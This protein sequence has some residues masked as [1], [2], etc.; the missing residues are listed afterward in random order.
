MVATL[1]LPKKML[2]TSKGSL[3]GGHIPAEQVLAIS[4]Q[5][6]QSLPLLFSEYKLGKGETS[7]RALQQ[8]NKQ[9]FM[10]VFVVIV[11]THSHQEP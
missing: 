3:H 5:R 7:K 6:R 11:F 2:V 8:L 1:L 4:V 10:L 9:K